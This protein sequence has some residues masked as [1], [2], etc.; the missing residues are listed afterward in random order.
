MIPRS[1]E[2]WVSVAGVPLRLRRRRI[3]VALLTGRTIVGGGGLVC[4][5]PV[6]AWRG[7]GSRGPASIGADGLGR[8]SFG[9]CGQ[10]NSGRTGIS[11]GMRTV[12]LGR[13][14]RAS[15]P[16][17]VKG[18]YPGW[19]DPTLAPDFGPAQVQ[20]LI[21]EFFFVL[22]RT[23]GVQ[24]PDHA[25]AFKPWHDHHKKYRKRSRLPDPSLVFA[26]RSACDG[27]GRAG[28]CAP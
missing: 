23:S 8:C 19:G 2:I 14:V 27:G 24:L 28:R 9:L 12:S 11:F 13:M 15:L 26:P 20:F 16:R 7:P 21:S 18:S 22:E 25:R 3:L 4:S 5:C 1:R 10:V 17:S 6:A